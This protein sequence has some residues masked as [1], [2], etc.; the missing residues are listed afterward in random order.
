ML[1]DIKVLLEYNINDLVEEGREYAPGQQPP[2]II[3]L[4]A[5]VGDALPADNFYL[6]QG[7]NL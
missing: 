5:S 3:H 4:V 6:K 1:R 2:S 7:F